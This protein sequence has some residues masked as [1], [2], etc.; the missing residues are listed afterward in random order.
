MD[1]RVTAGLPDIAVRGLDVVF[2]GINPGLSAAASGHHFVGRSN[3]FWR[4]LHLAGFTPHLIPA[5]EDRTI[6]RYGY[7]L[8]TVA[9]RA[10]A[11]AADLSP[12]EIVA[13]AE[14]FHQRIAS[15]APRYVAF[16]GKMAYAAL[17]GARDLAW[18]AQP[19][20]L[21]GARVWVLPNPSGRNR[22]FS[23]D[24]LVAAYRPLH[25]ELH[26]A[27]TAPYRRP[28]G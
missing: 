2:C 9:G 25:D 20:R 11:G 4:V 18:G 10:T 24:A 28:E 17:S 14:A 21:E 23:L 8:T 7:G 12:A 13:D 26:A 3:R 15:Y 22:A 19:G 27:N 1:E 16:L 6:L 5:E